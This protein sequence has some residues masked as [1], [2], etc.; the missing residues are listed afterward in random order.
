MKILDYQKS[1]DKKLVKKKVCIV[2]SNF[3]PIITNMLIKGALNKLKQSNISKITIY[4]VPG[5]YEI[6]TVI[7]NLI[8]RKKKKYVFDGFVALGCLIKGETPHFEYICSSV[9]NSIT[10]LGVKYKIPIGNGILTCNKKKQA[11]QRADPKLGNRGGNA[12]EAVISFFNL[13]QSDYEK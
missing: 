9:F 6:P 2:T 12:A 11:N 7:S 4:T 1:N 5:T 10:Y 8:D 13:F 3:Y